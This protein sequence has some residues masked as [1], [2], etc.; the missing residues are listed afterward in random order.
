MSNNTAYWDQRRSNVYSAVGGWIL[1][2][3][4]FSHGI[5]L[6]DDVIGKYSYMQIHVLNV[7]GKLPE[8][9][10]ADWM[11]ASF[12]FLSWPDSRIWC[13]QIGA[14]GGEANCSAAAAVAAG[15]QAA[16]SELY[17]GSTIVKGCE[18]LRSA[19]TKRQQG[20]SVKEIVEFE[21][22]RRRGR[23]DIAGFARPLVKGDERVD[24][25]LAYARALDF[26]VGPHEQFALEIEEYLGTEYDERMNMNGCIAAFCTDQGYSGEQLNNIAA[27]IVSSGIGAC[28]V[29]NIHRQQGSFLPLR[30]DDIEYTGKPIREVPT[31]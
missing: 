12:I 4:V 15:I 19:F 20:A 6:L 23:P 16:C 30:C 9:K 21:V 17:G 27:T 11:E 14:L 7:T 29:D 2:K 5:N 28:Y 24:I 8:R 25:L 3:G 13:N 26:P 1:G 22:S 31:D 18:F 10:I